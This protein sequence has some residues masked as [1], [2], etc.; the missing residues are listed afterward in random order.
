MLEKF[1]NWAEELPLTIALLAVICLMHAV[2][3]A[4][5]FPEP[6]GVLGR[7]GISLINVFRHGDTSHLAGN[8]LILVVAGSSVEPRLR[9]L[10]YLKLILITGLCATIAEFVLGGRPFA[11]LSGVCLGIGVYGVIRWARPVIALAWAAIIVIAIG[12]EFRFASETLAVFAHAGGALAGGITAMFGKMFGEKGPRLMPMQAKH[13]PY[14]LE[15]IEQT[16]EDDAAEAHEQFQEEGYEGMFVLVEGSKVLGVTGAHLAENS[17]DVVWLSWTYLNENARGEG[18]GQI[19]LDGLLGQLNDHGVRKIFIATSDYK[20]DGEEIYGDAM[21]FYR[22]LGAEE[23]MRIPDYHAPGET[24][25]VFGLVN[26]A[27]D[28]QPPEL[29]DE[30]VLGVRFT[31]I[32][33][34]SES[35]G[36]FGLNWELTGNGAQGLDDMI[37]AAR[38]QG[39]RA[40]F[41]ALPADGSDI[42]APML[43]SKGFVMYGRLKDYYAVGIDEVWWSKTLD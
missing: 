18:L 38:R 7:F 35:E 6:D 4:G 15:I 19:M 42:A 9:R 3:G 40:V 22:S 34:A 20:E 5:A 37:D 24:K 27:A 12:L 14:V 26:P 16:D 10:D 11:G 1:A 41:A 33:P 39:G 32:D 17:E 29:D 43:E 31:G 8:A 28:T 13:H 30:P 21:T 36:G 2:F 23:E 25:I